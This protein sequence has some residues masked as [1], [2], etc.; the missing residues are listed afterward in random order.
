VGIGAHLM[1]IWEFIRVN[2]GN[3]FCGCTVV[4]EGWEPTDPRKLGNISTKIWELIYVTW[5]LICEDIRTIY[6]AMRTTLQSVETMKL[7][8]DTWDFM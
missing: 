2:M 5:D 3:Y 1:N 8:C 6:A 4:C 7:I